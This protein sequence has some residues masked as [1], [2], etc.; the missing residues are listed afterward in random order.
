MKVKVQ[1][2]QYNSRMCFVCGLNNKFG[3]KA[4]FYELE[5][6]KL[7]AIFSPCINHQ[8][9]PGRLHG[10]IASAILD[11]AMGR[12]ILI[13]DERIWG[14]TVELNV[15]YKKPIPLDENIKIICELTSENTRFFE[16]EGKIILTNGE[17]AVIAHGKYIKMSIDKI[18]PEDFNDDQWY[19]AENNNDPKE[20]D[21]NS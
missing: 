2:K 19:K 20:I 12:A 21:I 1:N 7:V 16:G 6:D 14:V 10:G 4:S 11:E 8:G 5:N 3:L 9:Y 18:T 13:K 15:K 17:T